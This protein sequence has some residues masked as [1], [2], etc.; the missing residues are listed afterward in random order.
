MTDDPYPFPTSLV[1]TA[2][3]RGN[4]KRD[5]R[6]ELALRSEL[7]RRGYRFRPD[8]PVRLADRSRPARIDVAF[9][10]L[11]LA[12]FVDGCF[13]HSCPD[14]SNV[15]RANSTYWKPKLERNVERDRQID[16]ALRQAGWTPLRVWEHEPV[17]AAAD[18]VVE[19][20]DRIR[21]L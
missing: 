1:V 11:R 16:D 4:R 12:V 19:V 10:R 17:A 6:P 2:V 20:V 13:W 3:M 5:T 9:P 8:Y 21:G 18:K 7:H 14:H 15:P